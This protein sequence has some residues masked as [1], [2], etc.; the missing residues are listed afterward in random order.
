LVSLLGCASADGPAQLRWTVIGMEAAVSPGVTLRATSARDGEI[1]RLSS[2]GHVIHELPAG[3]WRLEAFVAE[4][5]APA[6]S[7]EVALTVA[8][9]TRVI[10]QPRVTV[11]VAVRM[12][13]AGPHL[14]DA[15]VTW[16][17]ED[18]EVIGVPELTPMT[19]E[20]RGQEGATLTGLP[21]LRRYVVS[22][23]HPTAQR[24][25]FVEQCVHTDGGSTV[26]CTVEVRP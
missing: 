8:E 3:A 18:L 7:Q 21:W 26:R 20:V 24:S 23:E 1:V 25:P 17:P 22:V 15:A 4:H 5:E 9:L 12:H 14:E 2:G 11:E 10:V 19:S 6:W 13:G 16:Q